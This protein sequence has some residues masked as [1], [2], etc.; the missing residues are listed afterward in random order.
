MK[1]SQPKIVSTTTVS[2]PR[3]ARA[4]LRAS[5]GWLLVIWGA[6]KLV[7]PAHGIEVSDWL[8][9]GWFSQR[10]VMTGFGI[11]EIGLGL[12]LMAGL[13][14][15]VA[16]PALAVITGATLLG[17]WRSIVDPWGWYMEGTNALFFPS[18]IIF[19]GVLVLLAEEWRPPARHSPHD[20]EPADPARAGR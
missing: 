13:W 7:N 20:I 3:A 9:F 5:L 6:D 12:L 18:L 8:Y 10:V 17:V 16:Y 4:F 14:K 2:M 19:A 1:N 15:R 11:V